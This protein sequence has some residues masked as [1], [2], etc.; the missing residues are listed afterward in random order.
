MTRQHNSWFSDSCAKRSQFI[1]TAPFSTGNLGL[2]KWQRRT[3]VSYLCF[4]SWQLWHTDLSRPPPHPHLPTASLWAISALFRHGWW[5]R[6]LYVISSRPAWSKQRF[7][8]LAHS[9]KCSKIMQLWTGI[10]LVMEKRRELRRE[11]G[12]CNV[13]SKCHFFYVVDVLL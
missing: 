10:V 8:P 13:H 12:I 4:I 2:R 11:I 7:S 6:R 3:V 5:H 1:I 9:T